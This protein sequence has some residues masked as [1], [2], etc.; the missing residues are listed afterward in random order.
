MH[1]AASAEAASGRLRSVHHDAIC[2]GA[3]PTSRTLEAVSIFSTSPNANSSAGFSE[4]S[5]VTRIFG[6]TVAAVVSPVLL[7][8]W[9]RINCVGDD[10]V[11]AHVS[12]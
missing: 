12:D 3:L 4:P 5:T 11:A 9:A 10:E 1:R 6:N 2:P 8:Y 7:P